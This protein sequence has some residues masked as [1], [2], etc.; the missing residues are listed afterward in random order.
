M[1]RSAEVRRILRRRRREHQGVARRIVETKRRG[2]DV[3]VVVSAMGDST[4][5]LLDLAQQVS[6]EPAEREMD[7]LLTAGER[8]SMGAVGDGHPRPR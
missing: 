4:D 1:P 8:I 2:I 3:A 6:P 5:D 7:M